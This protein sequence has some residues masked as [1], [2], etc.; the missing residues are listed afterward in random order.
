M[1]KLLSIASHCKMQHID[2]CGTGSGKNNATQCVICFTGE[3]E[4]IVTIEDAVELQLQKPHIVRL[5]TSTSQCWRYGRNYC[6]D[7]VI[8][9]LFVCAQTESLWV[10][11]GGEAFEMLQA[12]NTLG[13]GSMS[14]L[15]ANTPR[16]DCSYESMRWWQPRACRY[17]QYAEPSWVQTWLFR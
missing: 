9:T 5:E 11:V 10:S 15:H 12:M 8:V 6:A 14:T 17:L 2:L 7:L 16:D 13:D 3:G 1:A 4:R